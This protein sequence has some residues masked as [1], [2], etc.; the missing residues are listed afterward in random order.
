MG[1][2]LSTSS[3]SLAHAFVTEPGHTPTRWIFFLHGILGS[4]NNFRTL[5]RRWVQARP[6]LGLV[7]VDLRMHG[8]SQGFEPPHTIESAAKDLVA[9]EAEVTARGGTVC[10][11]VGHSFGGKVA[12]QYVADKRGELD[13]AWIID[14]TPGARPNAAGSESTVRVYQ[15]L[16]TL[17]PRFESRQAFNDAL[18]AGG[19]DAGM[20]QWLAMNV[21]SIPGGGYR[22][23][24]DLDAI[25]ALLGDY[26]EQDLW[27]V[28]ENPPGTI[29]IELIIGGRSK[30]LDEAD[31]QR[32][33]RAARQSPGRVDVH[34]IAGA[35][36]W[37][38][39]DA[40]DEL[41]ELL[42]ASSH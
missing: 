17:P 5:A 20:V 8:R 30:V 18:A 12:L 28:V 14:S 13:R 24:L 35:S 27:P 33:E 15:L 19:L 37:V 9:L 40:P 38:H 22:F 42:A 25:G 16:R 21:D 29:S 23:R 6:H 10:G 36:H 3:P 11:V 4:G 32:A 41:F 1:L 2:D 26:F 31:R 39:V 34:I 7:L